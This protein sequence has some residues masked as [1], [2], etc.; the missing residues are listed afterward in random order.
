MIHEG[1]RP[2]AGR[3]MPL[4]LCGI[5]LALLLASVPSTAAPQS[6][7]AQNDKAQSDKNKD[8]AE[9]IFDAM[10]QLPGN[11]PGFRVVHAKGIVCRGTFAATKEAADLSRAEHFR[12]PAV[13][14]TVRFS[15]GPPDPT[16]A[17]A[18]PDAAPRGMAIRFKLS[19]DKAT[20]IVSFS[21][22]GFFV[23]TGEDV[24]AFQCEGGNGSYEA[25]S[26]ADRSVFVHASPRFEVRAGSETYAHQLCHRS[27]LRQQ[28]LSFRRQKR[29][30]AGGALPDSSGCGPT[31]F[32]RRGGQ[33]QGSEFL[34]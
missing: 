33:G 29:T 32:D 27:V 9:Q 1:L 18:S 12:G 15:N 17:D 31:L 20:D 13:P 24:L 6:D 21:H 2:A 30:E 4:M 28:C 34:V 10:V 8:I 11:K 22:N 5:F 19:G 14:V 25:A 3:R 26:V 16:T 23:G 7:K